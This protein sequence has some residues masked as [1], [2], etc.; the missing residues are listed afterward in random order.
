[1]SAVLDQIPRDRMAQGRAALAAGDPVQAANLFHE[2]TLADPVDWE[3]RYWLS[4]ALTAAGEPALAA[5]TLDDARNLHATAAIRAAGADMARL[6]GDKAYCREIG[7]KFYAAKLM[8]AASVC[9]GRGLDFDNLEPESFIA[10]G[11]ALQHQGRMKEATDVFTAASELFSDAEAHEF[12]LYA[13][14]HAEDRLQRVLD[15]GRRW[16]QLYADT[17]AFP[18]PEFA[19]ERRADRRLRIGYLGPSFTRNQVAQFIGPVLEAHDPQAVEVFLYCVDPGF[20]AALPGHCT[21]RAIGALDDEAAAAM[22]R[23]DRIDILVDIW[24]HN[25]G[26]RL[27]VF[28]RRPAPIQIAWINFVQTTGLSCIDYVLHAQSMDAPGTAE[29]FC[30]EIWNLGEIMVPY[31]PPANRPALVATPALARGH[32]VYGSFN[33]PAKLSD[34]TVEAWAKILRAR[35]QDRLVLKYSYFV[36][37]VLQRATRARFAGWGANPDQLEFRGHTSGLDYLREFQDIDLALDPSPCP[38]GTTTCDALANGVPVLTLK[39]ADFY[40]RI[41]LPAVLPCGLPELV[42]ESWDDYVAKALDLTAD[43]A[44]LDALR[45]RTR[46][47]FDASAYRDEAGFTRRL[48]AAYRA[49]FARWLA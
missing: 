6:R 16:G 18:S 46:Q 8:A 19:V 38:G 2:A 41:G 14:F 33:N 25:A 49:M 36:D 21:V 31:R 15:E 12:L 37:P 7:M 28:A 47:G 40:A 27:P 3:S 22:I 34:A 48:E 45:T 29:A 20:E 43:H 35:P 4:S 23:A 1:M 44:A 26:G 9:L 17:A 24:G 11:L 5:Q 32:V 10:Y 39:G 13:L 30:E 42:A